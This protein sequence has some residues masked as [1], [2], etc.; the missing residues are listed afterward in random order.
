MIKQ[1]DSITIERFIIG[2]LNGLCGIVHC[3]EGSM[4]QILKSH[5]KDDKNAE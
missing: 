4:T 5:I 2:I 1:Y 3:N